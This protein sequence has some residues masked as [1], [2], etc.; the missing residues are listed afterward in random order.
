LRL[1][2]DSVTIVYRRGSRQMT[3]SPEEV[4]QARDEGIKFLMMT[5]PTRIIGNREGGVKFVECIQM[6]LGTPDASGRARPEVMPGTEFILQADTVIIA[7]GQDPSPVR[8]ALD[9]FVDL[10]KW[11]GIATE[12]DLS[13]KTPGVFAAGDIV[14]GPSSIIESVGQA[15]KAAASIHAYLGGGNGVSSAAGAT[16]AA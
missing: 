5:N 3:A 10:D 9:G 11:G 12:D 2:A 14:L 8:D 7:I 4:E 15:K 16:K 13:T 6:H 1:G